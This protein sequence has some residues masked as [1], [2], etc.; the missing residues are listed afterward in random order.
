[1]VR[2]FVLILG[3]VAIACPCSRAQDREYVTPLP[4]RDGAVASAP[5]QPRHHVRNEG[6]SD[7]A[8]LCVIS[9]ILANGMYQGVP[10]F[11]RTGHDEWT[12]ED[13]P[14][15]GSALWLAA[16]AAP[17]GYSPEKLQKLVDRVVPGE[18]YASHVGTDPEVLDRLSRDGYPIAVTMNTG[19]LYQNKPIHHFV[20]LLHYRTDGAACF[21]DNNDKPGV[22]RWLSANTFGRR[23]L[24]GGVLWAWIWTRKP[25]AGGQTAFILLAAALIIVIKASRRNPR[26]RQEQDHET[27]TGSLNRFAGVRTSSG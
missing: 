15:K 8:G 1:M 27:I 11:S 22:Y 24:D 20:S 7:G 14:G 4:A 18:R 26:N 10:G 25:P 9:S 5:V 16:K 12:S 21:M 17:G 3:L 2:K 6:G 13:A 23:T 19:E